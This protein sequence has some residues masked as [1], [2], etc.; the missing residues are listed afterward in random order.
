MRE[1][2]ARRRSRSRAVPHSEPVDVN[3]GTPAPVGQITDRREHLRPADEASLLAA[4]DELRVGG[5]SYSLV[6]VGTGRLLSDAWAVA[7]LAVVR[8]VGTDGTV[9]LHGARDLAVLVP[10]TA[11]SAGRAE[12]LAGEL[13]YVAAA[14][15]RG[16]AADVAPARLPVGIAH[17]HPS[18]SAAHISRA[19]HATMS[20]VEV[21]SDHGAGA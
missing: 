7:L 20:A 6:L 8:A 9:Y 12:A 21:A 1:P 19:A 16:R 14:A 15:I 4:L 18:A 10:R 17:S 11:A 13:P 5:Q 2:V 3:G